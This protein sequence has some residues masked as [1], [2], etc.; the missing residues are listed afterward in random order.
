SAAEAKRVEMMTLHDAALVAAKRTGFPVDG[1]QRCLHIVVESCVDMLTWQ[2]RAPRYSREQQKK[3]EDDGTWREP[4][5]DY[6]SACIDRVYGVVRTTRSGAVI[7]DGERSHNAPVADGTAQKTQTPS[8]EFGQ[9]L[10]SGS[11]GPRPVSDPIS[12]QDLGR[13]CADIDTRL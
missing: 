2:E 13:W 12:L 3:M 10:L 4:V 1:V 9:P 7:L 11:P 6:L 8:S 5:P